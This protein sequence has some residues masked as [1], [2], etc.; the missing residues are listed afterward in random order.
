MALVNRSPARDT[1]HTFRMSAQDKALIKRTA[2]E[3]GLTLQQL[4]EQRMFGAERPIPRVGRP[5]AR[6]QAEELPLA[7]TA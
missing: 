4:F 6:Q 1:S 3:A 2:Q 7:E 5:P